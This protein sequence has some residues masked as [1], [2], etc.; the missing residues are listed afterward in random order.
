MYI[1]QPD[2]SFDPLVGRLLIPQVIIQLIQRLPVHAA[3]VIRNM[4]HK[5]L[6]RSLTDNPQIH[7]GFAV[8]KAM[9]GSVLDN[10]LEDKPDNLVVIILVRKINMKTKPAGV[11]TIQQFNVIDDVGDLLL[12]RT[13]PVH[14]AGTVPQQLAENGDHVSR[15]DIIIQFCR[16]AD[17]L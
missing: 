3:A 1:L 12:K 8:V 5:A 4:K 15:L 6:V 2:S 11:T 9:I 7:E 14:I 10:R 17:G 16:H 13:M